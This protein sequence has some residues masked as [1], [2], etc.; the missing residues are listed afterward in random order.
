MTGLQGPVGDDGE[1]GATGNAGPVGTPGEEGAVG[2]KGLAG[3]PGQPVCATLYAYS[4][5][6]NMSGH[7]MSSV[8]IFCFLQGDNGVPGLP[9]AP[10]AI[11]PVVRLHMYNITHTYVTLTSPLLLPLHRALQA[12]PLDQLESLDH[13]EIL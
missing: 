13:L 4:C 1:A 8:V 2:E 7:V 6:I 5:C 3:H 12:L 9:G 11:G 10:G